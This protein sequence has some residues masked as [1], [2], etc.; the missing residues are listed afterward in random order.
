MHRLW[1]QQGFQLESIQRSILPRWW[2]VYRILPRWWAGNFLFFF[3]SFLFSSFSFFFP[4]EMV[5]RQTPLSGNE[6]KQWVDFPDAA[7]KRNQQI[8]E[9]RTYSGNSM[10]P[11]NQIQLRVFK[12]PIFFIRWH[13]KAPVAADKMN[14]ER[15]RNHWLGLLSAW[16][17]VSVFTRMAE[18]RQRRTILKPLDC[19]DSTKHWTISFGEKLQN[20]TECTA[21]DSSR[22]KTEIKSESFENA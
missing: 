7:E 19:W 6:L 8:Q 4:A 9:T 12:F 22:G 5:S 21:V 18:L 10:P 1:R 16:S 3:S 14:F 13:I 15:R 11:K 2:K 20:T 17:D